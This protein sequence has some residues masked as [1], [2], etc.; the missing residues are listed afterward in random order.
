MFVL[1]CLIFSGSCC[2]FVI[3]FVFF[4]CFVLLSSFREAFAIGIVPFLFVIS[5]RA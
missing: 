3:A 5:D 2:C 4:F 1:F